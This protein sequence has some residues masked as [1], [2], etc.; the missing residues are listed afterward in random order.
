[1]YRKLIMFTLQIRKKH[2]LHK[3]EDKIFNNVHIHL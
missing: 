2:K 3:N 1:M